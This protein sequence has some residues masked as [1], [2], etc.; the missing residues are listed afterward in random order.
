MRKTRA[1][2]LVELLVVIAIIGVLVALLLPAIQAAREAAR[3]SAC[4]NNLKQFGIA[5]HNYHDTL[6]TF[7]SAGCYADVG[8]FDNGANIYA[9]G[10]A[11]LLP[12]FE[13]AGLKSLYIQN[14]GWWRQG[15][16]VVSKVIPVFV[17]PSSGGDNPI[18]DKLL[19]TLFSY[20]GNGN[21]AQYSAFGSTNYVLC[22]GVTDAWCLANK[23][24]A[25]KPGTSQ[26][27]WTE[28]GMF[29]I[30]YAVNI[31]KIGD[32]TA[33]TIAV[34]E[35]AT[36]PNWP[37]NNYGSPPPNMPA[38]LGSP[39]TSGISYSTAGQVQDLRITPPFYNTAGQL[40]VAEQAWVAAQV[41]WKT[42]SN[43]TALY[44]AAIV[45]CTLEPMNKN[46][47]TNGLCNEMATSACGKSGPSAPGTKTGAGYTP[48]IGGTHLTPNF[49]SDHSGGCNFLMADGAVKFI[50][51]TINMLAYQQLSTIN[52]G[53]VVQ[54]PD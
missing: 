35:G 3:R 38:G 30:N 22:K 11:M 25:P 18:V 23:N 37:V 15:S 49:R 43:A 8:D 41:P 29:D 51:E 26:M 24:Q 52:G 17:C 20:A 27:P 33:N 6:K 28:R 47:V 21:G 10:H 19:N 48:T 39:G 32:G 7:P 40:A 14:K 12:Y 4:T 31:R 5:L 50:S 9:S 45:A 44:T 53:E 16:E 54:P 2:T 1:F 36:G 46:P 42:L 13:E 34:G